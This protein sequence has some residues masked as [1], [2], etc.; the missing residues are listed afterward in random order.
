MSRKF[1]N[2]MLPNVFYGNL[3]MHTAW[4]NGMLEIGAEATKFKWL[5]T[6]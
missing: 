2:L 4:K 5:K 1:Y 3:F 6:P